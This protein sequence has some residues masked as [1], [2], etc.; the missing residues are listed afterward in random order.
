MSRER[1]ENIMVVILGIVAFSSL[2]LF[3]YELLQLSQ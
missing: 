3:G 1:K 2:T